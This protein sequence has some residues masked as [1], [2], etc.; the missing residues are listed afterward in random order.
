MCCGSLAPWHHSKRQRPYGA[1]LNLVIS[2]VE[3][4]LLSFT[5]KGLL[6][7]GNCDRF[8]GKACHLSLGG[9]RT[10]RSPRMDTHCALSAA[11]CSSGGA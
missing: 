10:C 4:V 3:I 11:W 6:Y 2:T 9:I 5:G 7:H 1:R 8:R